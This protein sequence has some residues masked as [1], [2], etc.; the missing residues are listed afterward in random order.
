VLDELPARTEVTLQVELSAQEMAF[1]EALRRDAIAK[2]ADPTLEKGTKHLKVLAEIMQLR[3]ACCN[4]RLVKGN[5]ALPS[6]KLEAFGGILEELLE[7]HHKALVF[8]QFVDHLSIPARVSRR[9]KRDLPIP[10]RQHPHQGAQ[11]AGRCLSGR[12]RRRVFDQ[13]EGRGHGPESHG[14]RLRDSHGPLVEPGGGGSGQR[15][16]PPHRPA[17]PGHDL[18]PGGQK[19]HRRK[20]VDLHQQKRDL[21]DSLLEGADMSGKVSTE[22][23][24]QLISAG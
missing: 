3:R 24:L 1:Y 8:S 5:T 19:H 13:P 9:P 23:L 21:A 15:S 2:L 4:T 6:A 7:N 22:Q 11:K 17:A 14:C 16:R 12:G 20:I 10:R 18:S